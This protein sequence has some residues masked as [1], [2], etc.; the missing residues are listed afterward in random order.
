MF[1]DVLEKRIT[2]DGQPV[3]VPSETTPGK[4]VESIGKDP[5]TTS[6]VSR[7]ANGTTRYLPTQKPIRVR[8]GQDLES[9]MSGIGG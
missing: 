5:E 8:D 7:G 1:K 9:T 3:S 4:I 6:L 2:V